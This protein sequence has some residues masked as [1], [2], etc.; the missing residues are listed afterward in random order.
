MDEHD[1]IGKECIRAFRCPRCAAPIKDKG[2]YARCTECD[3]AIT[4]GSLNTSTGE[5]ESCD[6]DPS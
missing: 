6:E 5:F 2:S 4:N 3:W 1:D